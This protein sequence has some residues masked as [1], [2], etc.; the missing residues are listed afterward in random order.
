MTIQATILPQSH[1]YYQPTLDSFAEHHT[2]SECGMVWLILL[3]T[4]SLLAI[5]AYSLPETIEGDANRTREIRSLEML[6]MP[7]ANSHVTTQ[8]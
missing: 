6:T 4:V 8:H 3:A 1:F 7:R 5:I 2:R